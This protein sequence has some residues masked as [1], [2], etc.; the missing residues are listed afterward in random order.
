MDNKTTENKTL[1]S[2]GSNLS[3][4]DRGMQ[5]MAQ[6]PYA[7]KIYQ[8]TNNKNLPSID[9]HP[10]PISLP[11]ELSVDFLR[12]VV[13]FSGDITYTFSKNQF[14]LL[15][16]VVPHELQPL[17]EPFLIKKNIQYHYELRPLLTEYDCSTF[18]LSGTNAIDLLSL[19]CDNIPIPDGYNALYHSYAGWFRYGFIPDI[20]VFRKDPRAIV[21]SK[22]RGS[23]VGYDLT[24]I[25]YVEDMGNNTYL[26]DTGL[27][28]QPPNGYYIEIAPRSS[29]SKSGYILSN[30]VGFIDPPYLNTLKVPLTKKHP[31]VP[32]LQLPFTGFQLILRKHEHGHVVEVTQEE[33]ISTSRGLGGFG[34]TGSL[35]QH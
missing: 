33:L 24:V 25:S 18:K 28:V 21:P 32:D 35:N 4:Y 1:P 17:L 26:Y 15:R 6:K 2:E 3:D 14:Y 16:F 31:D 9:V 11:L 13:N 20:K 5:Y 22:K 8:L 34:S 29:F 10:N 19:L 30:S 12:G 7:N 23:D 27:V